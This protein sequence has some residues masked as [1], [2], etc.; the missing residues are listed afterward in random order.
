MYCAVHFCYREIHLLIS[1][2]THIDL[3]HRI[4]CYLATYYL[5][6]YPLTHILQYALIYFFLFQKLQYCRCFKWRSGIRRKWTDQSWSIFG[7]HRTTFDQSWS[8]FGILYWNFSLCFLLHCYLLCNLLCSNLY[9]TLC[10]NLFFLF[11]KLHQ[12]SSPATTTTMLLFKY[13]LFYYNFS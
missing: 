9:S 11:Q 3:F 5:I 7:L 10:F 6:F 4:S 13:A 12:S 8:I 1:S 2:L